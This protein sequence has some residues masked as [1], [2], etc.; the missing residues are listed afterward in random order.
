MKPPGVGMR[1]IQINDIKLAI[2]NLQGRSFMQDI[3]DPF[4]KA[5]QLIEEAKKRLILYLLTFMQKRHQK[6]MQWDGI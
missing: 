5:D 1:F 4:K 6:K 2:I 3:D